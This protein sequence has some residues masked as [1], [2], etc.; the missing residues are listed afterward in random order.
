MDIPAMLEA[1]KRLPPFE[2]S[3]A[4]TNFANRLAALSE[5]ML[6]DCSVI[7]TIGQDRIQPRRGLRTNLN[8]QQDYRATPFPAVLY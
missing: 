1:E 2:G 7:R 4:A 6:G 5:S 8:R 3:Q